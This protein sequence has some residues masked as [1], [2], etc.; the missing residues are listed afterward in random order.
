[1][2]VAFAWMRDGGIRLPG[3]GWRMNCGLK[4]ET[5]WAGSNRGF[6]NAVAGRDAVRTEQRH[7]AAPRHHASTQISREVARTLGRGRDERLTWPQRIEAA[8]FV[9][10]KEERAAP[11]P[12]GPA[13]RAAELVEAIPRPGSRD[14]IDRLQRLVAAEL[15]D[16][17]AQRARAR[18]GGHVDLTDALVLR[19]IRVVLDL[20]LLH[21]IERGRD[22]R[23]A[24]PRIGVGETVDLERDG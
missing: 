21:G 18:T 19:R 17:A 3:N 16:R 12:Q 14:R 22:G 1:M 11:W 9:R 15:E 6:A 5:G 7:R 2:R 23:R 4:P 20:E 10:K 13:D 24:E 8:A